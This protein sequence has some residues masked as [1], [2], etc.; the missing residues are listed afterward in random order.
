LAAARLHESSA[1]LPGS[2]TIVFRTATAE[3]ALFIVLA[4][5]LDLP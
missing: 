4:V 3:G 2:A 1:E 5:L